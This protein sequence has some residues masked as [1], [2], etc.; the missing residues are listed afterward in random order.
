MSCVATR[1]SGPPA[2]LMPNGSN[3]RQRS[4]SPAN[5]GGNRIGAR[6][7]LG[8]PVARRTPSTP[9]ARFDLAD[10]R[11]HV[12]RVAHDAGPGVFDRDVAELRIARRLASRRPAMV[13]GASILNGLAQGQKPLRSESLKSGAPTLSPKNSPPL[14]NLLTPKPP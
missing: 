5:A 9:Q 7:R 10:L 4:C 1:P 3:S 6:R 12:R 14:A 8:K 11:H 13:V 2:Q